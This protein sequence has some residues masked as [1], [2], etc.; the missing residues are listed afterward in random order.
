MNCRPNWQL[1]PADRPPLSSSSSA[2]PPLGAKT[3][4]VS[5]WVWIT[6][7]ASALAVVPGLVLWDA[8][9]TRQINHVEDLGLAKDVQWLGT[10]GKYWLLRTPTGAVLTLESPRGGWAMTSNTRL[11]RKTSAHGKRWICDAS[12]RHCLRTAD[13]QHTLTGG[14]RSWPVML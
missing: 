2:T 11:V 4:S 13:E 14:Q 3:R 12:M 1:T 7:M 6:Y 8:H 9:Q 5:N 10:H